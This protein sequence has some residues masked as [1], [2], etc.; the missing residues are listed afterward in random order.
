MTIPILV[1]ESKILL[2]F[3]NTSLIIHFL[4]FR[5]VQ[6]W[7]ENLA[8]TNQKA[9]QSLADPTEYENLFQGLKEAFKVEQF[10]RPQ[11][12]DTVPAASYLD[13]TVSH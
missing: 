4:Y 7:R 12:D 10:L 11:R 1:I 2:S 5:V 8:K 6:L 3:T 13:V 9:A